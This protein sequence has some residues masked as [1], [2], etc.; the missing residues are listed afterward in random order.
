MSKKKLLFSQSMD[1]AWELLMIADAT[2]HWSLV[3]Q[4]LIDYGKT[5][6]GTTT[7]REI[8]LK[9]RESNANT[10]LIAHKRCNS[11]DG[12]ARGIKLCH[13]DGTV[14]TEGYELYI[15]TKCTGEQEQ[16]KEWGSKEENIKRLSFSGTVLVESILDNIRILVANDPEPGSEIMCIPTSLDMFFDILEYCMKE[17]KASSFVSIDPTWMGDNLQKVREH[18]RYAALASKPE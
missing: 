11:A 7:F 16:E 8:E 4:S 13:P 15:N 10:Y 6:K 14:F 18:P 9:L 17:P 3:V 2:R 5:T 1:A 12:K